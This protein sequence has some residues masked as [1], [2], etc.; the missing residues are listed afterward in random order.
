MSMDAQ[1]TARG[2]RRRSGVRCRPPAGRW[3]TGA[4]VAFGAFFVA[5]AAYNAVVVV[6]RAADAYRDVA[7]VSWPG[8]DRLVLELVVPVATPLAVALVAFELGVALLV[9]S[10]GDTVRAGLLAAIVFMVALAPLMSLYELANV[11]LIV[12]ALVLLTREHER[13]LLDVLRSIRLS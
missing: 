1:R 13:S 5:M 12:L 6:P 8:V 10:A 11:P 2:A 3:L 4:R 7:H 9:L